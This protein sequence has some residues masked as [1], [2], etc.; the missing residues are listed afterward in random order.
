MHQRRIVHSVERV[1][2]RDD[3]AVA[4]PPKD[5]FPLGEFFAL[6]SEEQVV[7]VSS[8]AFQDGATH[9]LFVAG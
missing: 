4:E 3:P 6:R 8:V 7:V 5:D 1:R 9:A 2:I